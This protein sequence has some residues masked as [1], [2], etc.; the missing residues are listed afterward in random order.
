M[1]EATTGGK[2]ILGRRRHLLVD[3][4]GLLIGVKV[5][6][7]KLDDREGGKVLLF[8]LRGHLP[9]LQLIWADSG[10]DGSRFAQWVQDLLHVRV[11]IISH[12]SESLRRQAEAAAQGGQEPASVSKGFHVLPR[13]WVIERTNAWITNYRRLSR[14]YEGT[15][16]SSEA[17]IS[18]AM[19][20]LMLARLTRDV[21]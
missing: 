13:R 1:S 20:Q 10:Y 18:L 5:L 8:S 16:T 3:T 21:P 6:A 19:S 7:G 11:E 4:L 2:K 15:Y 14:D 12:L 9:R 17:F